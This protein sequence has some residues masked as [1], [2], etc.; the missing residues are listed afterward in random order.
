ALALAGP[1]RAAEPELTLAWQAPAGCPS[2]ADVEAQFARLIGGPSRLPSGK[3]ID[4]SAAVRSSA[5]DRWAL[6]LSTTLDGA[7]G[8]RALAGDSCAAVSSAAALILALMIDPAAAERAL[9][10]PPGAAPERAPPSPA[11]AAVVV[12]APSPEPRALHAYARAFGGALV[13]LLPAPAPAA[14]VAL[15]ARRGRLAAELSFVATDERRV[16]STGASQ[17]PASGDF[18]VLVGGARGC[19]TLGGRAVVWQLCAGGELE[20]LTG[21]GL[22]RPGMTETALMGAGTAGVLV[23][24]PLGRRFGLTLDVDGALRPYHPAFCAY[25]AMMQPGTPIARVPIASLFAAL[26]L[27]LTI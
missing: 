21:R 20:W 7:P 23:T 14:G 19:G 3:H 10:A 2:P 16:T 8:R 22:V 18:R 24:A 1:A 26:G 11:P 4:A 27:F 15:G 25:C 13:S 17:N 9:L 6:D 12:A 5:P